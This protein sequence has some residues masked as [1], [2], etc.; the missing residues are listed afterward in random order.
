MPILNL[1]PYPTTA[2]QA[3]LGVVDPSWIDRVTL[4]GLLSFDEAPSFDEVLSTCY[5]LLEV[6]FKERVLASH[7]TT[8][9]VDGPN[10]LM[11]TLAPMM[12]GAGFS[13]VYPLKPGSA[14]LIS[15][16]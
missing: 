16:L 8:V 15:L 13:L 3:D 9:M 4:S 14:E 2:S 7:A 6:A 10:Y 5:P 1:T 12:K 11:V